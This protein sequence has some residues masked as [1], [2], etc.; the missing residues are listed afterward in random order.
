MIRERA[1]SLA[2]ALLAGVVLVVI[3]AQF[4]NVTVASRVARNAY[5][6]Q[7]ANA[8]LG[9]AALTRAAAGQ[10]AIFEGLDDA[11]L[12]RSRALSTAVAELADTRGSF[13]TYIDQAP[14]PIDPSVTSFVDTLDALPLDMDAVDA[15]YWPV[16]DWLGS[17]QDQIRTDI[18]S[19]QEG[20][21]RLSIAMR[22]ALTLALPILAI[23]FYRRRAAAEVRR[24][25]LKM[26]AELEAQREV[27]RAKDE[28][29]SAM[30]H[31]I[32]TPLT[33]ILGFSELL[34]DSPP[35]AGAD[36]DLV[37][38]I[39]SEANDL[40]RMV[41]D[42]IIASRLAGSGVTIDIRPTDLGPIVGDA[43]RRMKRLGADVVTEGESSALAD[44]GRVAHILNNLIS[45]AHRHGGDR[46][47]VVVADSATAVSVTVIDDG[48]GIPDEM[49]GRL[50]ER[51]PHRSSDVLVSGS[52]GLGLWVARELARKMGGDVTYERRRST[53]RFTLF[54]PR[55]PARMETAED[56][57]GALASRLG[58]AG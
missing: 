22:L 32:R 45:N 42:F 14:A 15:A 40:N 54:L 21:A 44:P 8:T 12:D 47:A 16:A 3:A 28:F 27:R 34:L 24:A 55:V 58:V 49:A 31:E 7:W 4:T 50:F 33:G 38:V 13:E 17:L 9:S 29:V 26:G 43:V 5:R 51:F 37:G 48:E 25:E 2:V 41:D 6:L 57:P 53:T 18:A 52:L 20:A 11:G 10:V 1:R 19:S 23:L 35:D 36:R 39:N 30:S 46:V 56:P